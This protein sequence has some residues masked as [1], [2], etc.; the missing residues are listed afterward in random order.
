MDSCEPGVLALGPGIAALGAYGLFVGA[1]AWFRPGSP[2]FRRYVLYLN[3]PAEYADSVERLFDPERERFERNALWRARLTYPAFGVLMLAFGC[4]GTVTVLQCMSASAAIAALIG[5]LEFRFW[6]PMVGFIALVGL[7]AISAL[8]RYPWRVRALPAAGL[9]A[10]AFAAGE[11][12]AFH[13][14]IQAARWAI[15]AFYGPVVAAAGAFLARRARAPR[16]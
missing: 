2:F 3:A 16:S 15:I 6:P 10:W 12:A 11:A 14:G 8:R 9:T 7:V 4:W 1:L 5:P 13:T